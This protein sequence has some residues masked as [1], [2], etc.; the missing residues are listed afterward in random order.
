MADSKRV[1]VFP[2]DDA[3]PEAVVPSL[4]VLKAFDVSISYEIP[5]LNEAELAERIVSDDLKH[6]IRSA[7]AVLFGAGSRLALPILLYLRWGLDNYANIRPTFYMEGTLSRL[8]DP[9]KIDYVIVREKSGGT[10]PR[11]GGRVY[12]S[13][14]L[15]CLMFKISQGGKFSGTF[16]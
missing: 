14:K 9:T 6:Q 7:D 12:Q 2:G 8:S 3:S 5:E 10:L 11:A 1:L 4:D 15:L 16:I 13:C